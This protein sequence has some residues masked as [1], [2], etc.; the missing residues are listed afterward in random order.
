[1]KIDL[2]KKNKKTNTF[3]VIYYVNNFRNNNFIKNKKKN[4]NFINLTR[5]ESC[6][7]NWYILYLNKE[8]LY[9]R[10]LKT[11]RSGRY[12]M[13]LDEYKKDNNGHL[14][15]QKKKLPLKLPHSDR[16][17]QPPEFNDLQARFSS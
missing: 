8:L 13:E 15:T 10:L 3:Y 12:V 7:F 9:S 17:P 1:M 16:L 11:N 6:I 4:C 2:E 14:N 5:A